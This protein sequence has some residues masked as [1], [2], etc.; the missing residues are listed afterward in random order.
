[1]DSEARKRL[2]GE[3][4]ARC[5]RAEYDGAAT[6]TLRGYGPEVLGF[7]VATLRN[8]ADADESFSQWSEHLWRKLPSFSW[9]SSLR[10][11]AYA[12]ARNV[13]SNVR[14]N[15]GRRQRRERT[16]RE[17]VFSRVAAQV[18]TETQTFLRTERRSRLEA[19][20]NELSEEDRALLILRVDRRLE[21]LEIAHVLLPRDDAD[22]PPDS[23]AVHRAA[24]R[25]RKRFQVLKERLRERVKEEG[26]A[27]NN[28]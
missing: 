8:E 1:M 26:I 3:V 14:R 21:W 27:R 5:D 25:C 2:E 6:L 7:L 19:L 22:S 12:I 17:S 28:H 23:V 24:A 13:S 20:R 10:T 9:E 11:W 18:R 4:R 16:D 15:E